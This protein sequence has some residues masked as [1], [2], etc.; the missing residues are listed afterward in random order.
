MKG[1]EA[2][3][4]KVRFRVLPYSHAVLSL[5]HL[6][7][8]SSPF[9][10]FLSCLHPSNFLPTSLF[11]LSSDE[12]EERKK[13]EGQKERGTREEESEAEQRVRRERGKECRDVITR[14]C[15]RPRENQWV[16]EFIFRKDSLVSV[17]YPQ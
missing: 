9:L 13:R 10:W 2:R 14:Q 12:P 1:I 8:S 15:V 11:T 6:S 4:L 7:L 5:L 17:S 3:G 16:E